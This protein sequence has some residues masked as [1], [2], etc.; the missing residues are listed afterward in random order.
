MTIR[1]KRLMAL[2]ICISGLA[3]LAQPARPVEIHDRIVSSDST[4]NRI[5]L[6]LDA[7]SGKFDEDVVN[8]F[9]PQPHSGHAVRHRQMAAR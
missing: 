1:V 5:A 4:S 9:N 3:A 8:F 6:T 2:F 7:C